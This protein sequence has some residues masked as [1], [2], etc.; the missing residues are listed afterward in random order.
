MQKSQAHDIIWVNIQIEEGHYFVSRDN[1][2][3]VIR[4]DIIHRDLGF[5]IF[6]QPV[7]VSN[8]IVCLSNNSFRVVH[9]HGYNVMDF[10][11]FV[12]E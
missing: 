12:R 9:A 11:N 10:C 3:L 1:S 5:H 2:S 4:L 6:Q 7:D 8:I